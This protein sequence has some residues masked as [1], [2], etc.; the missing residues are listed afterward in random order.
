VKYRTVM[1]VAAVA[2]MLAGLAF[3]L[4]GPQLLGFYGIVQPPGFTEPNMSFYRMRS[5]SFVVGMVLFGFGLVTW[6]ARKI[7]EPM[8]QRSI[9]FGHFYAYLAACLI[10]L[11]QQIALWD[12]LGGW[13]SVA[14]FL[15]LAEGFGY[16]GFD[17]LADALSI[18]RSTFN[19]DGESLRERWKHDIGAAAAQQERNRLARDLH[20][21]IKQQ[22]FTIGVGAAAAQAR[23]ESDPSGAHAALDDVRGSAHEAMVEMEAMLQ[24]LSPAPLETIGLVEALRKQCEALQ[25]RTGAQVATEF[26]DLP[27][28]DRFPPGTQEAI[29]RIAQEALANIARHAR[30]QNVKLK[31]CPDSK[32][33]WMLFLIEDDGQGFNPANIKEGMGMTNIRTR[34]REM[35]GQVDLRSEPGGGARLSVRIPLLKAAEQEAGWNFIIGVLN[36]FAV[37]LIVGLY[38]MINW[39]DK[40]VALLAIPFASPFFMLAISRFARARRIIRSASKKVNWLHMISQGLRN[41]W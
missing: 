33:E 3:G 25:Y 32:N 1:T 4:E 17:A 18:R 13:I 15:V 35:G 8:M 10:T 28:N 5:F 9:A 11:C 31:L 40:H 26:A 2:V 39:S 20:D 14:F 29:F 7:T 16:L 36:T 34:T 22:I 23:W 41:R 30:A 19:G 21:S 6:R 12:T 37:M 38:L 24:H 27:E